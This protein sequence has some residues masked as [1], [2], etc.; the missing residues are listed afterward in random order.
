MYA[1]NISIL[2]SD[3]HVPYLTS[4]KGDDAGEH[5]YYSVKSLYIRQLC[6]LNLAFY[7]AKCIDTA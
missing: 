4:K 5:Y 7:I 6:I 3:V 1:G 2:F